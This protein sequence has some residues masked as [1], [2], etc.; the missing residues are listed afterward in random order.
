MIAMINERLPA[1]CK[2]VYVNEDTK[3]ERGWWVYVRENA[4]VNSYPWEEWE[5]I[6]ADIRAAKAGRYG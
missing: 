5:V 3:R 1:N 2:L 6:Q 4:R